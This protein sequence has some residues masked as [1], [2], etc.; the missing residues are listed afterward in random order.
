M[1]LDPQKNDR[2]LPRDPFMMIGNVVGIHVD[3]DVMTDGRVDIKKLKPI[4][5]LGYLEYAVVG[6][7]NIFAMR[8]PNE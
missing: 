1:F 7:D 3:D 6:A 5:R 8:R 4:A 2:G